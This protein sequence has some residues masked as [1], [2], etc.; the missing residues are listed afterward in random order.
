MP[1]NLRLC[2]IKITKLFTIL[3]PLPLPPPNSSATG[4]DL[5]LFAGQP[6]NKLARQAPLTAF[7]FVFPH[8]F[9]SSFLTQEF[10]HLE[11][12][13]N[14]YRMREMFSRC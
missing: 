12:C 5:P 3:A 13:V 14:L 9:G 10:F 4:I 6:G 7:F 2:P 8:A 11:F 1:P